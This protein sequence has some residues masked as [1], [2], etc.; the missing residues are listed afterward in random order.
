MCFSGPKPG[1][2]IW[3]HETGWEAEFPEIVDDICK[4]SFLQRWFKKPW[5]TFSCIFE[6]YQI[7]TT[8]GTLVPEKLGSL[9]RSSGAVA[10][11]PLLPLFPPSSTR[12][13]Q[14]SSLADAAAAETA[15]LQ[16]LQGNDWACGSPTRPTH[17]A[18]MYLTGLRVPWRKPFISMQSL[19]PFSRV[20]VE[21]I[22]GN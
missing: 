1:G 12:A 22:S 5:Q 8:Q 20:F 6:V 17:S 10:L 19:L 15:A 3:G 7:E 11:T 9:S 21:K 4:Y 2:E 13:S 14:T 18:L 16:P